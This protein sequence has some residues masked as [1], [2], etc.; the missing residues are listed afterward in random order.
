MARDQQF[1]SMAA[2]HVADQQELVTLRAGLAEAVVEIERLERALRWLGRQDANGW[3][4]QKVN[5][6][7]S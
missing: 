7:L 6:V 4:K 1:P 5:E 3:V 2:K